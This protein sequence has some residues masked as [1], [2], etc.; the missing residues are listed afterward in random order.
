MDNILDDLD[1]NYQECIGEM[2]LGGEWSV[3]PVVPE[4]KKRGRRKMKVEPP[5]NNRR[6]TEFVAVRKQMPRKESL[7]WEQVPALNVKYL[8]QEP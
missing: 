4:K 2:E 7:F 5:T 3:K 8:E 6:M 1:M